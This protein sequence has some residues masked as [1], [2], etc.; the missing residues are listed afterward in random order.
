MLS[1]VETAEDEEARKNA[2]LSAISILIAVVGQIASAVNSLRPSAA[3]LLSR[4]SP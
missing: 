1:I 4:C 3:S 2:I